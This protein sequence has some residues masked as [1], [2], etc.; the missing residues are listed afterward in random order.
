MNLD[1]PPRNENRTAIVN[2]I[3]RVGIFIRVLG[4][5][6]VQ[7]VT[8][9]KSGFQVRGGHSVRLPYLQTTVCPYSF[10]R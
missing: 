8:C 7:G 1:S 9:Q 2:L 10:Y 3:L 6:R 4:S 5:D